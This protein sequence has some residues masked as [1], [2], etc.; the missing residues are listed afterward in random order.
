MNA[1]A[2]SGT[3]QSA[4]H[5]PLDNIDTNCSQIVHIVDP[6]LLPQHASEQARIC[7]LSCALMRMWCMHNSAW[8]CP[9]QV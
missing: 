7:Q 2:L 8:R 6:A 4:R 1:I 9:A 3:W 5:N